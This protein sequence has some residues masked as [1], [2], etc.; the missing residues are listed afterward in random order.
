VGG[1]VDGIGMMRIAIGHQVDFVRATTKYGGRL[2]WGGSCVFMT[3]DSLG[4][5]EIPFADELD[6][7][8]AAMNTWNDQPGCS[9]VRFMMDAPEPLEA[10]YDGKNVIKFRQD[11]WCHAG[12]CDVPKNIYPH[13]ANAITTLVYVERNGAPDDG[14][15]LDADTEINAVNDSYAVH[16]ETGCE[17]TP[18][19][20]GDIFDLQNTMTHELGHTLGLAHTCDDMHVPYDPALAPVDDTGQPIPSCS[21]PDLPPK[22]TGAVMYN[23]QAPMQISK[24]TL[25]P[26]D[27]NAVCT[28]YPTAN[29]PHVCAPVDLSAGGCAVG[30]RGGTSGGPIALALAALVVT[31][32][33][34]SRSRRR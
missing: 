9:Y 23:F 28:I 4:T 13:N 7:I 3:V 22:V 2:H 31:G 33:A 32:R 1:S 6:A 34:C 5:S 27:V 21:D 20:K 29:D 12:V 11:K 16:C 19:L 26:D 18:P 25:S 8:Q 14:T 15:I 30:G 17:T 24:R 10:S